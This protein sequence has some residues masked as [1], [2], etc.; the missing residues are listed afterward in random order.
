MHG[1]Q[2]DRD[3]CLYV[4]QISTYFGVSM[5]YSENIVVFV[6]AQILWDLRDKF[7]LDVVSGRWPVRCTFER[8]ARVQ[9]VSCLQVCLC[10]PLSHYVQCAHQ[11]RVFSRCSCHRFANCSAPFN[12]EPVGCRG[13]IGSLISFTAEEH[14][15]P[16]ACDVRRGIYAASTASG[17][18]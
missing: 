7:P 3:P 8:I 13:Q 5:A 18:P 11:R 9:A 1:S 6:T 4:S 14:D 16:L 10:Y 2:K 17:S 12:T 15:F